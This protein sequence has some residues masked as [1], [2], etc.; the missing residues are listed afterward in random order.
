MG[1]DPGI[2]TLILLE[3]TVGP[4]WS[5]PCPWKH[6][7]VPSLSRAPAFCSHSQLFL[8]KAWEDSHK[9]N[10]SWLNIC[11]TLWFAVYRWHRSH[12]RLNT[13][14][15]YLSHTLVH[16][17][18]GTMKDSTSHTRLSILQG[19]LSNIMSCHTAFISRI[20]SCVDIPFGPKCIPILISE[21]NDGLTGGL[22]AVVWNQTNPLDLPD[23]LNFLCIYSVHWINEPLMRFHGLNNKQ[24]SQEKDYN[25]S[26]K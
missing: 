8:L 16:Q 24:L 21:K 6:P 22:T 1:G 13:E 9:A 4:P 19:F 26:R 17:L 15:F 23:S 25:K 11:V 10:L 20:M 12:C 18:H 5:E 14:A 3:F 7:P 2:S